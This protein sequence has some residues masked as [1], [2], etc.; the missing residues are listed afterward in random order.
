MQATARRLSVVSATS[1]A[2][3]RLIRD[4]RQR[5]MEYPAIAIR[6][7][8][9]AILIRDETYWKNFPIGFR[10]MF[11]RGREPL[12]IYGSQGHKWTLTDII[13]VTPPGWIDRLFH[14]LRGVEV[15]PELEPVGEYSSQELVNVLRTAVEADDDILCQHDDAETI[16]S[17]LDA[18]DT[19]PKVFRQFRWMLRDFT[20]KNR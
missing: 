18:C 7:G 17:K 12:N 9:L 20:P 11:L 1:C 4:V 19:I 16:L 2:R 10:S 13:F 14:G 6:R 3:R 8:G 5:L 15:H